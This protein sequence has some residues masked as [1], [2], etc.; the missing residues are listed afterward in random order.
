MQNINIKQIELMSIMPN[1]RYKR[2]P[3]SF[4]QY[5]YNQYII[6]REQIT[7]RYSINRN[8]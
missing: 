1:L 7:N 6:V 4:D 8:T 3:M 2:I 5:L